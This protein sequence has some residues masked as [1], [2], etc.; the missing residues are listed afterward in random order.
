MSYE[1]YLKFSAGI[2]TKSFKS[3]L[4]DSPSESEPETVAVEDNAFDYGFLIT[5]PIAKLFYDD[6]MFKVKENWNIKPKTNI[7]LGYSLTNLGDEI[8]Y[9]DQVQSDPIP[10]TAR[11]GYNINIGFD[12]VEDDFQFN[13]LDY[14]FITEAED[15]LITRDESNNYKTEYQDWMGDI[16]FGKHVIGLKGDDKVVVRKAHM[17]RFLETFSYSVG[18][19]DGRGFPNRKSNGYVISTAGLS[20]YLSANFDNDI[21]QFIADHISIE[22]YSSTLFVD[23]WETEIEGIGIFLKNFSF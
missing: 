21:V 19:F 14:Y 4:S 1:F 5:A 12:L 16:S 17:F 11:L 15:I 22:Y 23:W 13:L 9:F 18:R 7:S 20:K 2:T 3:V 10:R 6:V 8:L